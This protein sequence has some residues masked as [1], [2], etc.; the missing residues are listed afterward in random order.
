MTKDNMLGRQNCVW[1]GIN[2]NMKWDDQVCDFK[3]N[4][5]ICHRSRITDGISIKSIVFLN[6]TAGVTHLRTVFWDIERARKS[7]DWRKDRSFLHWNNKSSFSNRSKTMH[8]A[9]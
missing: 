5:A 2:P 6:K 3:L 1:V 9:F 4:Y 8:G 7:S